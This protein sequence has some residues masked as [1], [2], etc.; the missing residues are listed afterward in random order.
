MFYKW[1]SIEMFMKQPTTIYRYQ[2]K[3]LYNYFSVLD[4]P[5]D[6]EEVYKNG[7]QKSGEFMI[8]P[9]TDAQPYMVYCDMEIVPG[10]GKS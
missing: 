6:C 5:K 10:H 7:F 3:F 2:H 1:Q 9:T 4:L 8:Y